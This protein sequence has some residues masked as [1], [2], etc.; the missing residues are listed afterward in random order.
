MRG[1][2][3][4]SH[5]HQV[6]VGLAGNCHAI[7][8][9]VHGHRDRTEIIPRRSSVMIRRSLYVSLPP[10]LPSRSA[11]LAR[12]QSTALDEAYLTYY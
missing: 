10:L 3:A 6:M 11:K 9:I 12:L 7:D 8:E 2:V 1:L 5:L 4:S